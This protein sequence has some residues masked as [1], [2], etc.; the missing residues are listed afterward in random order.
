MIRGNS[1]ENGEGSM[2]Q[3]NIFYFES[4]KTLWSFCQQVIKASIT[5]I[6]RVRLLLFPCVFWTAEQETFFPW[7]RPRCSALN[8]CV[9][10]QGAVG[11]GGDKHK[12]VELSTLSSPDTPGCSCGQWAA[13][14]W[15]AASAAPTPS[16]RSAD[17]SSAASFHRWK[18]GCDGPAAHNT[19]RNQLYYE[20]MK[21]KWD[22]VFAQIS[23]ENLQLCGRPWLSGAAA[24]PQRQVA[25]KICA[26]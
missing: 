18:P 13:P 26:I 25:R 20:I 7:K 10:L 16:C 22:A 2:R 6:N 3:E 11:G 5:L 15:P 19:R 24:S 12:W 1:L 17:T 14:C 23:P 21:A 9:S 4:I 8:H